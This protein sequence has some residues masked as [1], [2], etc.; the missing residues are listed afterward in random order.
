[1]ALNEDDREYCLKI[2]NHDR[3]VGFDFYLMSFHK[4]E[5]LKVLVANSYNFAE[6]VDYVFD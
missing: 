2:I 1:M 3:M 4:G 5:T 6:A